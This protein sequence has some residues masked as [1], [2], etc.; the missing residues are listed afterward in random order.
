MTF[1][2]LKDIVRLVIFFGGGGHTTI[3]K[4]H[5]SLHDIAAYSRLLHG[6]FHSV[7]IF[8]HYIVLV[9]N[10]TV[11]LFPFIGASPKIAQFLSLAVFPEGLHASDHNFDFRIRLPTVDCISVSFFI[12]TRRYGA[13]I[14][15]FD[16]LHRRSSP[17]RQKP[18]SNIPVSESVSHGPLHP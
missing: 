2:R 10:Y 13:R 17:K 6:R 12:S 9:Q 15:C 18:Q 11:C 5:C 8:T 3:S 16:F 4:L 14:P 1:G 7:P